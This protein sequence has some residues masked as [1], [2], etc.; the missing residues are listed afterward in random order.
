M[1]GGSAPWEIIEGD[2][3]LV[4]RD[5][6]AAS[7]DA[8]VTDPPY[9][10]GG[11]F[12]SD[13]AKGTAAKYSGVGS[14]GLPDFHGDSRG[15]RGLEL[16]VTLWMCEALRVVKPGGACAVFCDWR[17][18]PA[19]SAA[20]EAAGWSWRG[21]G[22]WSKPRHTTRPT[23][24][25][26]WNDSELVFT[27]STEAESDPA[28]R[29]ILWGSKGVRTAEG[30]E[31]L[32]GSWYCAA[33][34]EGRLH[35]TEKPQEVLRDLVRLAPEGGLVLDPFAGSAS[36][37]VAA[38]DQGRRF[39]GIELSTDYV[40]VGRDRLTARESAWADVLGTPGTLWGASDS[41]PDAV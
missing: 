24:G 16:W 3:L 5:L 19:F 30:N 2:S 18:Y 14:Y 31:Y 27:G 6:P 35:Q 26:L 28:P 34:R 29:P 11:Q 23:P 38:L 4:L 15:E 40:R 12:R 7:V 1:S 17:S 22:V 37:G 41:E 10:S 32:P 25:G 39:L 21:I 36:T 13:R 20:I 8:L 33:P 9:S